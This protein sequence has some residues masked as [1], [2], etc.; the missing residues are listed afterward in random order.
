MTNTRIVLESDAAEW[1]Q[2][3]MAVSLHS[4]TLHSQETPGFLN[5]LR[6][7]CA[8]L[9]AAL[10]RGESKYRKKYDSRLDFGRAWWTPPCAPHDAVLLEREHIEKHL[11]LCAL[12]SLTDHDDVDGPL[13]LRVTEDC[14]DLPISL[15]WTVPYCGTFLHLG[16]H[17]LAYRRAGALMDELRSVTANPKSSALS[18]IL[19][20]LDKE[21]EVLIVLNHACWDEKASDRISMP[22]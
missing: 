14:R 22:Q 17:N 13:S 15:E 12:V 21:P 2:F 5:R 9:A 4:H 3:R 6:R 20:T 8:P 18:T 10:R 1:R 7:R 19:R 16:I 11:G